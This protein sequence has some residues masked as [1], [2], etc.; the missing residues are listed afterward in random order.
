MD[1][2]EQ[3]SKKHQFIKDELGTW[4]TSF[5][6]KVVGIAEVLDRTEIRKDG[7]PKA[8]LLAGMQGGSTKNGQA[9]ILASG[10]PETLYELAKAL[11]NHESL[12]ALIT[13]VVTDKLLDERANEGDDEEEPPLTGLLPEQLN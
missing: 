7:E 13:M 9:A 4:K 2:G 5:I 8:F 10:T 6:K 11:V 1:N 3:R 12:G